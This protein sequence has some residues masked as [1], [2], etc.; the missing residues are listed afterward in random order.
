MKTARDPRHLKRVQAV[1]ELFSFQFNSKTRIKTDLTKEVIRQLTKLDK[2]I[3]QTAPEWP[4]SQINKI[5]LAILRLAIYE[6]TVSKD[7]PYKVIVDEAVELG[8]KYGADS[9]PGFINGVL[10]KVISEYHLDR[11]TKLTINTEWNRGIDKP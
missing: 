7:A 6:L 4:L 8:K 10:G 11:S 2:V 1:E 3:S 9:S 5:D